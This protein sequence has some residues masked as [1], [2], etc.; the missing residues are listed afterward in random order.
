MRLLIAVKSC[1]RDLLDGAHEAIRETWGKNLPLNVDLLFFVGGE[2][3]PALQDDERHVLAPDGYWELHPKI[4]EILDYGVRH[5]YDFIDLCDTDTYFVISKLMSSGFENY[6]YS[7]GPINPKDAA[8][9]VAYESTRTSSNYGN[10]VISPFYAYLSGGHGTILSQ[11][12]AKLIVGAPRGLWNSEDLIIGQILGPGIQTGELKAKVLDNFANQIVHPD[13]SHGG[14]AAWH[15]G[16]GYYGGGHTDGRVNVSAA[17][18][19]KHQE[20]TGEN[21]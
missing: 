16:C 3:P 15:L 2:N 12:A 13:K 14:P 9:G 1:Q 4:L 19:K 10:Y 6:D 5:D 20:I 17:L 11:R 8:F 7:G 18:K 21:Q